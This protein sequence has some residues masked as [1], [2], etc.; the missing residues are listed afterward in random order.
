MHHHE[1]LEKLSHEFC[2]KIEPQ[3]QTSMLTIPAVAEYFS[4][5]P[6]AR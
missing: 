5:H 2:V 6:K 3:D 4:T 1:L